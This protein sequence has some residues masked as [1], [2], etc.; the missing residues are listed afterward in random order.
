MR[1]IPHPRKLFDYC[2]SLRPRRTE[3]RGPPTKTIFSLSPTPPKPPKALRTPPPSHDPF[4][5]G[6]SSVSWTWVLGLP[7]V[8]IH[9]GPLTGS[10]LWGLG[11]LGKGMVIPTFKGVHQDPLPQLS[12]TCQGPA[13]EARKAKPN[14]RTVA[15]FDDVWK[16]PELC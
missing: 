9:A 2:N 11:V 1:R 14:S 4:P 6:P 10:G 7:R 3:L 15:H 5:S 13:D 12:T 16:L 8:K